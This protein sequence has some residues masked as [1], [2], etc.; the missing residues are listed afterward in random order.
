MASLTP[1]EKEIWAGVRRPGSEQKSAVESEQDK[2]EKNIDWGTYQTDITGTTVTTYS[3]HSTYLQNNAGFTASEA[4]T[5]NDKIKANLTDDDASGTT[6]DEYE[7]EVGNLGSWDEWTNLFD[8]QNTFGSQAESQDGGPA[9]G[10]RTFESDGYTFDGVA[11]PA[12]T[13]EIFGREVHFSEQAPP[14]TASPDFSYANLVVSNTLPNPYER[15]DISADITNNGDYGTA[16]VVYKED[17]SVEDRKSVT[18]AGGSTKTV[19]FT[20]YWTE[21]VSVDVTID[22]LPAETVSVVP[23]GLIQ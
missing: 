5:L 10:I 2:L 8:T 12:G 17:G 16:E 23:E 14:T 11:A 20:T 18:I 15:V 1:K 6:W 4:A 9:A 22:G 7:A 3:E 21:Y 13:V 19:T